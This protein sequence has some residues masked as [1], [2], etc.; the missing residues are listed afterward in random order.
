VFTV[1][2]SSHLATNWVPYRVMRKGCVLVNSSTAATFTQ[3]S[4]DCWFDV[5]VY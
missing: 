5:Q 4:A 2:A 3:G 1:A